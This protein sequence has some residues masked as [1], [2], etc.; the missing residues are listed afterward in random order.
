LPDTCDAVAGCQHTPVA[1]PTA[2]S[3]LVP[4]GASGDV[5]LEHPGRL[6]GPQCGARQEVNLPVKVNKKGKKS[7]GV[8]MMTAMAKAP[9]G[10]KPMKD[11]DSYV[12][13]CVRGC[14]PK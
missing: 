13:K 3:T 5:H 9:K 10:T 4:G 1:D 14:I 11:G 8:V 6:A 2:C 7:T 12:L